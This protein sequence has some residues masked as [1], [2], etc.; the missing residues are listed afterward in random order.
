MFSIP[1]RRQPSTALVVVAA[2]VAAALLAGGC[3]EGPKQS[4]GPNAF[5]YATN[6]AEN[7]IS[8]YAVNS[9]TGALSPLPEFPLET[10][11]DS[12]PSRI[13]A[14]PSGDFLYVSTSAGCSGYRV[15]RQSGRLT[16]I[17]GSPF[18]CPGDEVVDPTG[19]FLISITDADLCC[20]GVPANLFVSKIANATGALT[21]LGNTTLPLFTRFPSLPALTADSRLLFVSNGKFIQIF[22][23]DPTSGFL[24][25]TAASPFQPP[26]EPGSPAV[27]GDFLFVAS[28]SNGI[29]VYS[30]NSATGELATA[31][32]SP[33]QIERFPL[34]LTEHPSGK[35][36]YAVDCP[37]PSCPSRSVGI[38]A[39][40]IDANTGSLTIATGVPIV[41]FEPERASL[42]IEPSGNFL[43]AATSHYAVFG[44]RIDPTTGSLTPL[45]ASPFASNTETVSLAVVPREQISP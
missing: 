27:V 13:V 43:Y 19:E 40:A 4:E 39:L 12:R 38:S 7:S 34:W 29:A 17:A 1:E 26:Q 24:T 20:G 8:G 28:H 41:G 22:N 45:E 30:I 21:L 35:F 5:L 9:T 44:Y 33:F 11:P 23:F 2:L 18:S 16:E 37:L 10:G 14:T 31:D 3:N 15:N 42:A 25:E 36:L 32:G 6:R